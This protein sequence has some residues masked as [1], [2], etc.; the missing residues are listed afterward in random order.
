MLDSRILLRFLARFGLPL[1]LAGHSNE[2]LKPTTLKLFAANGTE[3]ALQGEVELT[4]T[5][6]GH[7][8]IAAVVVSEKVDDL[9]LGIDWLSRHRCRW[10][11]ARI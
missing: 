8:V 3:I 10:S 2:L 7:E 4:M 11:F 5:L 1:L 9:I 6:S